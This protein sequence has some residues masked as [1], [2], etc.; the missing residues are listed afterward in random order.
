MTYILHAF[1]A[2][3]LSRTW[4]SKVHNSNARLFAAS[5]LFL[6]LLA[7]PALQLGVG[8]D[9]EDYIS[10]AAGESPTA[11]FFKKSELLYYYLINAITI[12]GSPPHLFI[13]A[14]SLLN[15]ILLFNVFRKLKVHGY[16]VSVLIILFL[17][18]TGMYQNQMNAIR[19][20]TAIYAFLNAVIY[21]SERKTAALLFFSAV[22]ILAH[23]SYI[24]GLIL[25][26]IP[27]SMLVRIPKSPWFWYLASLVGTLILSQPVTLHFIINSIFPYYSHYLDTN[28]LSPADPINI[29][30][31]AY[32]LPINIL[33]IYTLHSTRSRLSS[34][35]KHLIS[36]WLL[37]SWFF[38]TLFTSGL[39]F[40]RAWHYL[41]FF[42]IIPIY[43]VLTQRKTKQLAPFIFLLIIT[44]FLLKVLAFPQGEYHYKTIMGA[45]CDFPWGAPQC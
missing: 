30:T 33:F 42:Q 22:G 38:L 34:L 2:F 15:T 3:F 8:T 9:Y 44:P 21:K 10:L 27:S 18:I 17:I 13:V 5:I 39:L 41:A 29:A 36:Y 32:L 6:L 35:E 20:Y 40:F 26:S 37:S 1:L 31:K 28:N 12:T 23:Q 16:Q 24:L 11:V 25:L 7:I 4:E 14:S 19:N 45:V 43:Y